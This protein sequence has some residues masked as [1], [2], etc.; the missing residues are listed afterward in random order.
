MFVIANFS[1]TTANYFSHMD[2]N[3]LSAQALIQTTQPTV[4]NTGVSMDPNQGVTALLVNNNAKTSYEPITFVLDNSA[5]SE[6]K[7][8]A[9]LDAY[10]LGASALGATYSTPDSLGNGLSPAAVKANLAGSL[11]FAV[12]F[13]NYEATTSAAQLNNAIKYITSD[14][15]GEVRIRSINNQAR[16]RNTSFD[17]KLLSFDLL[18]PI[19][20][21]ANNFL[22]LTVNAGEKVSLTLG[23]SG[24]F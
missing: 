10:G 21:S 16:K 22:V 5:G 23:F 19:I 3:Q 14:I 11:T 24:K 7:T 17:G 15:D 1:Y 4:F 18:Q 6:A 13:M 9:I 8:Y 2:Q 12:S 20:W